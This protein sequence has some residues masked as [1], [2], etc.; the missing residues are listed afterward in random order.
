M[1][2][3]LYFG[4]TLCI[5]IIVKLC[6]KLCYEFKSRRWGLLNSTVNSLISPS[7]GKRLYSRTGELGEKREVIYIFKL[8]ILVNI[9]LDASIKCKWRNTLKSYIKII[10]ILRFIV[11]F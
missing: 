8:F 5:I 3:L 2:S 1:C 7:P 11:I 6:S 9:G 4:F 10:F